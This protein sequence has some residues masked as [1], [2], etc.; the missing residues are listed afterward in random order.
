M[1]AHCLLALMLASLTLPAL[2][3]RESLKEIAAKLT[4]L[5]GTTPAQWRITWT[6]DASTEA[7]ISWSTAEAGSKH[8]V[9]YGTSAHGQEV[10][11]YEHRQVCQRSGVYSN[12]K[13]VEPAHY[14][15]AQLKG[16][17]PATRY[18][19]VLES[20]GELSRP[21]YFI[22]SPAEGTHFSLIHGGD[23]RTGHL[24]RCH[25]N[26]MIAETVAKNPKIVGFIH[27]GDFINNGKK[28]SE[29]RLWLSQHELTT[30]EDGRVLPVI[31][32]RGNHEPGPIYREVFHVPAE[33]PDWHTTMVGKDIAVV[34]LDTNVPAAGEQAKWCAQELKR[35]RPKVTWL[36]TQYHRPLYPAVKNQTAH[37]KVFPP[38][39]DQYKVDLAC[40][41]DGHCIKRTI[42][43]RDNKPDPTGV[44]YI[45]EGGLGV[46]QRKPRT[47]DWYLKGGVVGSEHH[48]M[49]LDFSPETLRIRTLLLDGTV[50]DDH[51]L[52]VRK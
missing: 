8:V 14:H 37:A 10:S 51:S 12:S 7:I 9:H 25:V 34:T 36:L 3:E 11:Q 35:L 18:H 31:P 19:F 13:S 17:K 20:D 21:L 43:I 28:W 39:F 27:G 48:F 49:L 45:G 30:G 44:T 24:A 15:H 23:S 38:I 22:T 46:G 33:G 2:A 41:S 42:P 29:W 40:E 47:D 32:A 6:G 52:K 50:F 1:K 26:Q 5:K 16:L 4:P